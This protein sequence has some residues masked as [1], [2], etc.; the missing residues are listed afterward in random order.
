MIRRSFKIKMLRSTDQLKKILF[1]IYTTKFKNKSLIKLR[2]IK[3]N[4]FFWK[5]I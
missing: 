5:N 4:Y 1:S 3:K 2:K